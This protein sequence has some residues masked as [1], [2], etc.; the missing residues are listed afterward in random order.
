M[1]R[2][3]FLSSAGVAA[4]GVAGLT[5]FST[6]QT[7]G[8]GNTPMKRLAMLLLMDTRSTGRLSLS[9][10]AGNS[11]LLGGP[12]T[13]TAGFNQS[14]LGPTIIMQNGPL[15]INVHNTLDEPITT[16]WHG[17]MV[18]GEHDGGPHLAIRSG[19]RWKPDVN[20]SQPSATAWYHS[21]IHGRTAP[22]VYYG[23][24]GAIHVTDGRD[25]YRGL[26][27]EYGVDDLTLILQDRRFDRSGRMVYAPSMM[28]RMQGF[29]GNRI[30]VNGQADT[31]AVVPR[32]I[33]RLRLLNASNARTYN[34]YFDDTRPLHLIATDGGY[35][36]APVGLDML[37][38]SPGERA[39]VL[40]DFSGAGAPVLMSDPQQAYGV[41]QF[42]TDDTT[43]RIV[44]IPPSLDGQ[45]SD[46]AGSVTRTRNIS[47]DMGM[48][49]MMM[50]G[51]AFAINGRPFDMGRI[52]FEVDLGSV[53][54]WL[55]RSTMIAHPF[56]VHG[57]RF[58]VV[59]ENG[60]PPRPENTGWKDTVLVKGE[61]EIVARFDQPASTS[62]PY[63]FHCH[64]LE[65]EDAGMMAQFTVS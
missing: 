29:V 53:E 2:R 16:H 50:G 51:G 6:L 42:A 4:I 1:N 26:P 44:K 61:T 47:L 63:M 35:L 54:R 62:S 20:I 34:L 25:D 11:S 60:R 30:L 59:S 37:R 8:A 57:V 52:D 10:V 5:G 19:G 31:T 27:A 3:Q 28:D 55:V 64:I 24:A 12:V 18:P 9:T 17:L 46:L 14:Y 45:L 13:R 49:G 32:G 15:G 40:V 56:H 38:L 22:Q 7:L 23:L 39:E 21:H 33:V 41:L 43:A 58:R 65:H 36:P 48:G